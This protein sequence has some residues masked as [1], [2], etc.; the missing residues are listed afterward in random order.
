MTEYKKGIDVSEHN[1]VIDWDKVKESGMVDFVMIR[2]GYGTLTVDKKFYQ[3]AASCERVGIPYG[4]YWFSYAKTVDEAKAEAVKCR[5]TISGHKIDYPVAFDWEDDSLLRAKKAGVNIKGRDLPTQFAVAFLNEIRK[6]G[7]E[8]MLYTNKAFLDSYFDPHLLDG[9]DFW[10]ANWRSPIFSSPIKYAGIAPQI[11]Q[12]SA[13]GSIPGITGDVD[14]NICYQEYKKEEEELTPDQIYDGLMTKLNFQKQ[15][16]W[17][18]TEVTK[19]KE[20]GFTDGSNPYAIPSRAEVMAMINRALG[21]APKVVNRELGAVVSRLAETID[22]L[23]KVV[24]SDDS[25]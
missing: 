15:S 4:V 6:S 8:P 23:R 22:D 13:K 25:K 19:A 1:G 7:Y 18:E 9:F 21:E 24:G 11:W 12:Y 17:A 3:N 5:I 2:A 14:L 10:Y 20:F 16:S